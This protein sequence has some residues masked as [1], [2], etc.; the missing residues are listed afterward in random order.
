[1]SKEPISREKETCD[2]LFGDRAQTAA[3]AAR[4]MNFSSR[5]SDYFDVGRN[6][7]VSEKARCYVAG[8]VMKAPRKNMERMEEYVEAYNYQAQQQFLSD[9][10][11][12]KEGLDRQIAQDVNEVLGGSDAALTIDESG[13]EKKGKASVGVARQWNGRLGKVDNCQVGVYAGLCTGNRASLLGHKLYL[14]EEWTRDPDRCL[15]AGIPEE[16][17]VFKTKAQLALDLVDE[18]IEQCVEFGHVSVDGGYGKEPWFLRALNERKLLFTADVHSSQRVYLEDPRPHVPAGTGRGR[19]RTRL[20]AQVEPVRVDEVFSEGVGWNRVRI[21]ESTKGTLFS[22]ACRRRVWVWDGEEA[23][24]IQWWLVCVRDR[25]TG[26]HK[27]FLSNAAKRTTLTRLVRMQ[28]ARY[29]IERVFQDAKTSVGMA[30]YQVRKWWGWQHHM[31]LVMLALLFM[32]QERVIHQRDVRLLTCQDIV[33]LLNFYL[34]RKDLTEESVLRN[35]TNRHN[36]RR[37]SIFD[38]YAKQG[39][40]PPPEIS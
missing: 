29:W 35:I 37:Q 18:A 19:R 28:A 32:L 36:K 13:F 9:S 17:I 22:S 12:D 11:W 6:H 24:A 5:Y 39:R 14:P 16:A 21:R 25:K 40:L 38:A 1:M 3:V 34:P 31:S 2:E 23:A 8:L 20:V 33:E 15:K 4:F 27:W 7:N 26:E 30:D 10:P